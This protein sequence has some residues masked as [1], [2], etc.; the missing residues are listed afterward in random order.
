[1]ANPA[2]NRHA[3]YLTSRRRPLVAPPHPFALIV[4]LG[5]VVALAV[6]AAALAHANL[7]GAQPADGAVVGNPPAAVRLYFDDAIR[8][9][10]GIRAVSDTG[11]SV[12]GG[13]GYVVGG[14]ELVIPLRG[15]LDHGG[16]TVLWRVLSD[17]G[18]P[19]AGLTTFAVGAG[20]PPPRAV[21]AV[22]SEERAVPGFE[23]WLFLSGVLLVVGLSV[24]K[25]VLPREAAPSL[26][27]LAAGF[28]LTAGGG[29]A[30]VESTSLSTRFGLVVA[31][32]VGVAI[33]GA[34]ASLAAAVVPRLA[35]IAWFCGLALVLAP[36]AAGH[37][38]DRRTP[39]VEFPIDVLHV[40]A[41]SVW[42]GGLVALVLGA[43]RGVF[44]EDVVRRF[45]ALALTAVA[46]IG[47]TGLVRALSELSSFGQIWET[48][49]GR[50]LIAKTALFGA[51]IILGWANRYRLVPAFERASPR[52]RRNLGA[53]IVLL[54]GLI[55]VVAILT[56]SRP[57]RDRAFAARAVATVRAR[58][59]AEEP[60]E[61][62]VLAQTRN[63]LELAGG[64]ASGLSLGGRSVLWETVPDDTGGP[65]VLVERNLE[66]RRTR[67]LASGVASQYGLAAT[68]GAIVYATA[69]VPVQ[70]VAVDRR[71]GR[72]SVLS[73]SLAAPFARRG[74][75]I[76]WAEERGGRQ[77]VVVDDLRPHKAWTAADLPSCVEGSCYRIDGVTLADRGVVFVRGAIGPH[78]SFVVRREFSRSR[79]EQARIEGDPQPDLVPSATGALYYALNRGWY[80]WDFGASQPRRVGALGSPSVAPIGFDGRRWL[81]L[82]H[83]GCD[84][85]LVEGVR[86]GATTPVA[87]PAR[88]RRVVGSDR[89]N[90]CVRFQGA[91]WGGDRPVTTWLVVPRATHS[92]GAT[93][94][95][96]VGPSGRA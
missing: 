52:L 80:R 50:L 35:S 66:T 31:V 85:E 79:L 49:Y 23:R 14:R 44:R 10:E 77:R 58:R 73:H 67:T 2:R 68:N 75:R 33:A 7:V 41:S 18:H 9:Q 24:F 51:L 3:R 95:L 13:Q 37:A 56:Q 64:A 11:G 22:P 91:T 88:I 8:V 19:V 39:R 83:H 53:E 34:A 42:F 48:G 55:A 62:V 4:F 76:A 96:L 71:S 45:S 46:L 38:L 78:A 26:R 21:L 72:R 82:Q 1:V 20:Q 87:T 25:L 47:A 59:V 60:A 36:S 92:E 61:A 5:L 28:V 90:I 57:G 74:D 86:P 93:G 30:L 29:A 17:D 84:D 69:T 12:L 81:L 43:R 6:P 94:V 70:L 15:R 63:S 40:A 54:L 89:A 16:Y 32:A 27:L 65:A